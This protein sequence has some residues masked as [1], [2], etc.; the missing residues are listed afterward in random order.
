LGEPPKRLTIETV[1][2]LVAEHF[3]LRIADLKSK[4]RQRAFAH[5]RQIAMYLARKLTN[6]SYPDIGEKFGG[7]DHTTV[8]HN[9]RKIEE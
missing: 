5:P 6:S 9:V 3:K 4:R 2:K 7:K 1:Q 8:M